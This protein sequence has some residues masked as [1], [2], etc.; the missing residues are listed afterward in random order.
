MTIQK[1]RYNTYGQYRYLH[2]RLIDGQTTYTL[3]AQNDAFL[4]HSMQQHGNINVAFPLTTI[5]GKT[6][7]TT[8]QDVLPMLHDSASGTIDEG[9]YYVYDAFLSK[10][11][12]A[13]KSNLTKTS[14][15]N[16]SL[17][18]S[19]R[20]SSYSLGNYS[21]YTTGISFNYVKNNQLLYTVFKPVAVR[22][23]S[24]YSMTS[25]GAYI[26]SGI[27]QLPVINISGSSDLPMNQLACNWAYDTT[28]D[29]NFNSALI[30]PNSLWGCNEIY[31]ICR[32]EAFS[33]SGVRFQA[34]PNI[35]APPI[36][37]SNENV[38]THNQLDGSSLHS[39]NYG[40]FGN[41]LI[42]ERF[43]SVNN[44]GY[45]E[46]YDL[47]QTSNLSTYS[48]SSGIVTNRNPSAYNNLDRL[49]SL[50]TEMILNFTF[51]EIYLRLSGLQ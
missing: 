19:L 15:I 3:S 5:S 22:P 32:A 42:G 49:S 4:S 12:Y 7:L 39:E 41:K 10:L 1:P 14:N 26:G 2:P 40:S 18:F 29:P 47:L 11:R 45:T 43:S 51:K 48:N 25:A 21:F 8:L 46:F 36:P 17:K 34:P 27:Q 16:L 37:V 30:N 28:V 6:R 9:V 38:L 20:K 23:N 50:K 33:I 31:H 13:A 24:L 35:V 44:A